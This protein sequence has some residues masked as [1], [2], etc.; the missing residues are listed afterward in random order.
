MA[1]KITYNRDNFPI[2]VTD[3]ADKILVEGQRDA[4][5][6]IFGK[7]DKAKIN[8]ANVI[9]DE[10]AEHAEESLEAAKDAAKTVATGGVG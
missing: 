3:T 5:E 2:K 4:T 10:S 6:T 7:G 9:A 8:A 1:F